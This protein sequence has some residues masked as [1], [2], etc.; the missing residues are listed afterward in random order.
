MPF[1]D[2]AFDFVVSNLAIHKIKGQK[3]QAQAIDEALRVLKPGGRLLIADLMWTRT[4]A[5]LLR[6]RGLEDVVERRPD[7]RL[8][9]EALA[10]A[11]GLVT[12]TKPTSLN[13]SG[14]S[15]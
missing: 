5:E 11:T 4:Y 13:S 15:A 8:W 12:A 14:E 1:P 3:G 10:L 7:W 2:S 9:Y 6:E